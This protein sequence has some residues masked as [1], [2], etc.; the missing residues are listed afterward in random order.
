MVNTGL[1][2]VSIIIGDASG[3]LRCRHLLEQEGMVAFFDAENVM[4]VVVLEDLDVRGIGTQAV[5][6]DN[7]LEIGWS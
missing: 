4:E 2:G 7:H 1:R 6:G 5:F 3:L